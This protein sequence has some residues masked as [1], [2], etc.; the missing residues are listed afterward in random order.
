M[1][2]FERDSD[3]ELLLKIQGIYHEIIQAHNANYYFQKEEEL[4]ELF[5]RVSNGHF[6]V[7]DQLRELL[8]DIYSMNVEI[9]QLVQMEKGRME[10]SEKVTRKYYP[11]DPLIASAFFDKKG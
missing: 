2:K 3:F 6:V 8:E 4:D 7:T 9:V 11:S 1:N 10:Q 5:G